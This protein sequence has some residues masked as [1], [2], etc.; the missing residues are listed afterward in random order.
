MAA[1][2]ELTEFVRILAEWASAS[3]GARIYVFGSRVRGEHRPDSDLDV[4]VEFEGITRDELAWW[5]DHQRDNFQEIQSKLP[6]KLS[7]LDPSDP[8]RQKITRAP[9]AYRDRNVLCVMTPAKAA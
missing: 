6:C 1:T 5:L 9:V 2:A 3:P 7:L 4:Y 8:L